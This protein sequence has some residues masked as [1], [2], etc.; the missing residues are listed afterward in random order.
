MKVI[1][2]DVDGVINS[3][4]SVMALHAEEVAAYAHGKHNPLLSSHIDPIAVK[5]LN[6]IC[7]SHD[8]KLVISS[9][10]RFHVKSGLLADL[11][12]YFRDFGLTG[13]V[14]GATPREPSAHRGSEIKLWLDSHPDVERYA[15]LDDST[16]MLEEQL[17]CFVRTDALEG[18]SLANCQQLERVLFP[19]GESSIFQQSVA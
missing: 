11:Q 19:N 1:F 17:P 8:I 15:I 10:H 12:R 9:T 18:L 5:L 7:E 3:V 14:I 6:A 16:D 2:L 13:H 4:R